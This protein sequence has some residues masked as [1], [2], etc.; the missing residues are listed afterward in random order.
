[1][2]YTKIQA[3]DLY[4]HYINRYIHMYIYI[5]LHIYV[6]MNTYIYVYLPINGV[7]K[8]ILD[9]YLSMSQACSQNPSAH[10]GIIKDTVST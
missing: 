8:V 4:Q 9:K 6:Y 2:Y 5:N 3:F 1:M 10:K 7:D